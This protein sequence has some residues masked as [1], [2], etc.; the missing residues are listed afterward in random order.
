MCCKIVKPPVD[1]SLL[2]ELEELRKKLKAALIKIN[3]QDVT[4]EELRAQL[5]ALN[6][7]ES[8][9]SNERSEKSRLN[10]QLTQMEKKNADLLQMEKTRL[11]N[12]AARADMMKA[13]NALKN[14]FD[15]VKTQH[16]NEVATLKSEYDME[17]NDLKLK[18]AELEELIEIKSEQLSNANSKYRDLKNLIQT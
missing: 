10:Q 14:E 6:D 18:N 2:D 8:E 4:I 9:L 12:E 7:T 11:E 1:N 16:M 13:M 5:V 15:S 17:I 3:D